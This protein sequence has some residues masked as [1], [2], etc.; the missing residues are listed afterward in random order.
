MHSAVTPTRPVKPILVVEDDPDSRWM[1]EELLKGEGYAAVVASHGEEALEVAREHQPCLIL[2]DLMMPV[3]DGR[4]FR[5]EQVKDPEISE[6]PVI[7]VSAHPDACGIAE[8]MKAIGCISK[9][10]LFEALLQ[11]VQGYCDCEPPR[12]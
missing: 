7:I 5:R 12:A 6:I 2:L 3:L 10:I 4:G 11:K 8:D 1:L 9:P